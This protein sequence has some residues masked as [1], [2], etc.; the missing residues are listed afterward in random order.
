M[1]RILTLSVIEPKRLSANL[2]AMRSLPR[3]LRQ[4]E[5]LLHREGSGL[6]GAVGGR[7]RIRRGCLAGEEQLLLERLRQSGASFAAAGPEYRIGAADI[8]VGGPAGRL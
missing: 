5:D 8:G 1:A 4:S 2:S 6:P 7:K 3:E